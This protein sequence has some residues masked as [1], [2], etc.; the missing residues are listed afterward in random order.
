MNTLPTTTPPIYL[1]SLKAAGESLKHI[2]T[3]QTGE[4]NL[5]YPTHYGITLGKSYQDA[6]TGFKGVA[7]ILTEH[8][9]GCC[10]IALQPCTDDVSKFTDYQFFDYQ[11]LSEV[12]GPVLRF[13]DFADDVPYFD[14]GDKVKDKMSGFTGMT[15]MRVYRLNG[16]ADYA[17]QPAVSEKEPGKMPESW[18]LP[19]ITLEHVEKKPPLPKSDT[20]SVSMGKSL[21]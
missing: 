16:S 6:V 19:A 20:G 13:P 12:D 18:S 2:F 15:T 5:A 3:R 4:T 14:L 9:N 1:R 11:R 17:L 10:Q 8:I 7:I 21:F